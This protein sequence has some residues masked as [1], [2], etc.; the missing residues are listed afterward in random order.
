MWTWSN[1]LHDQVRAGLRPLRVNFDETGIRYFQD[2]RQGHLT[3]AAVRQRRTPRSLMRLVTKGETRA[4]MS[5]ATFVCDDAAVQAM[6]PQVLVVNK[7]LLTQ[8]EMVVA[9]IGL[10]PQVYIWREEKAWTTGEIMIRLLKELRRC[11]EP[12]LA[13][14]QVILSA[15]A[16]RA[17]LTKPVFRTAANLGFFYFLIPSKMT[18]ALQPLDTHVFAVFKRD[19]AERAQCVVAASESGTL[20]R[21]L[22][23]DCVGQT[24]DSV[25]R[26]RCWRRAFE[27]CGL[28]GT[29]VTVSA[30]T[31]C[32]LGTVSPPPSSRGLPSL[33]MLIDIFPARATVPIDDVF[34]AFLPAPAAR[35]TEPTAAVPL[36]ASLLEEAPDPRWPW[37]ERLR[38]SSALRRDSQDSAAADPAWPASP[39]PTAKE[40][41]ARAPPE[42]ALPVGQRRF[43]VGRPLGPPLRRPS[44]TR[45]PVPA[46]ALAPGA[47]SSRASSA[48]KSSR[49][50]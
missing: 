22:L 15:D 39:P 27:D 48:S 37:R 25:L 28:T 33:D 10:P 2:T 29:Q 5:L 31:L 18:W 40:R 35:A 7:K 1:F 14:R 50:T 4:M 6:L 21:P 13:E 19:L 47:S 41:T 38:S 44:P 9:K 20:T 16:F 46:L 43:P 45:D 42:N 26:R 8:D 32:K 3:E 24:V 30:R 49:E 23:I 11:L 34:R 12:V 17:H 36:A